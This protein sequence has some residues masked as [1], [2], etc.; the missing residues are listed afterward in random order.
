MRLPRLL[1]TAQVARHGDRL[2]ILVEGEHDFELEGDPMLVMRLLRALDGTTPIDEI[3]ARVGT[4]VEE[5]RAGI[6]ALVEAGLVDDAAA[7][8]ELLTPAEAERYDRQLRYFGDIGAE[9]RAVHQRRLGEATVCVLGLGGLGGMAAL[10]LAAAGVGRIVGVDGDEVELS[11]LARQVAYTEADVGRPKTAAMGDRLRALRGDLDYTAVPRVLD[12]AAAVAAAIDGADAVVAAVDWPAARIGAWVD[13]ACFAARV[14]Y[15]SMSQH[16]PLVRIGPTYLPGRTGCHACERAAHRER[17]PGYDE[18]LAQ[19]EDASPAATF[20]PACGVIGSLV[21]NEI[22]AVLSGL[23]PPAC[24]GRSALVDLRT[25]RMFFEEHP[26]RSDCPLCGRV[27]T[28]TTPEEAL[29]D[30]VLPPQPRGAAAHVLP[31]VL[32]A[33]P[34]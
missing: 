18:L 17:F 12:S 27:R 2:L 7:D 22:I 24:A 28:G 15:V 4:Q 30:E 11:N 9:P 31:A 6:A 13:E 8:L 3:A 20:A 19:T 1:P 23:H 34:G 33:R 5:V 14:P 32:V 16:P 21:A 10:M 26:R 25:L 29:F